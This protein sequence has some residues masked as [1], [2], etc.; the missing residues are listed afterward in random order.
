MPPQHNMAG[1]MPPNAGGAGIQPPGGMA[2]H[3]GMA[4]QQPG[5]GM[6]GPP[7]GAPPRSSTAPTASAMPV[8]DGMPTPWPLPTKTQ[9]IR[10]TNQAVAGAN[11]AVQDNSVGAG[12][13]PVGEVLQAHE[14]QHVKT[15]FEM[16]LNNS[17]QDGNL[18]KRDDIAKRLEELYNRLSTGQIKTLAS[19]KVVQLAQAA[20]QNDFATANKL[21]ME[22]CTV[23]WDANK[24]WL[25]GVKRLLPTR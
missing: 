7:G 24:G 10:A 9:S 16:L 3:P 25:M 6:G 14:L 15:V 5:M 4:P 8:T 2:A 12:L 20:E 18:R 13:A 22:L 1:V 23:D 17:A 21:Q 11:Q 19:Q